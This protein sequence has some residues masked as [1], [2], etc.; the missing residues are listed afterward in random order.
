MGGYGCQ[1]WQKRAAMHQPAPGSRLAPRRQWLVAVALAVALVGVTGRLAFW[2]IG[3]HTALAAIANAQHLHAL[4]LA[5]GRGTIRDRNGDILAVT[6]SGDAVVLD[7]Q[8]TRA[9]SGAEPDVIAALVAA[10]GV[11]R[12]TI[13]AQLSLPTAYHL[14]AD[15]S[16][17]VVHLDA[18]V[19]D[20][21]GAR[22]AAGD[23]PGVALAPQ[24]WRVAPDGALASQVLGFVQMDSGAGQYGI[25]QD[26]NGVLAGTP[27]MLYTAVDAFGN[28]IASAPQRE[29]PAIPGGDV[30]LTL[31]A[32]L[33]AIAEQGLAATVAQEHASGG[34][35][36]IEDPATGAILALANAPD[37]DPNHYAAAPLADF[38][39]PAIA[40]AYDPGSTMKAM[41]MAAGIDS[42]VITPDTTLV[43]G[44]SF[45]VGSQ[46]I[47]NWGHLAWGLETMTQV[48]Q[49]SANVGAAWVAVDELGK[50]RFDRYLS[51]FGFGAPA[52]IGLPGE[53]AGLLAPNEPNADLA[54][55][56]LA[57]NAVGESIGV[58]PLQM[59]MAYGALADGGLLMR[60]RIVQSVTRDGRTTTF[61][62]VTVRR[63]VSPAAA[64]TVTQ[65][66]VE[67][68][69]HS[70]AEMWRF[71]QCAVAAKTGTST[72]DP[73]NPSVTFASV[74]GYFP[75]QAPHYVVLVKIDHPQTTIFGGAAAGPLW[76]ALARQLVALDALAPQGGQ[77]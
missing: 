31:D 56:D 24:S 32:S 23:L 18:Q 61:A 15:A 60:P 49:H 68:S 51:A 44:G 35:V 64:A 54:T 53:S 10:T 7:P 55:L 34:T 2:Q 62:P 57:E 73:A 45:T 3:Q 12:A 20:A 39:N 14:L 75:A 63:V 70:D 66:L 9:D 69:Q 8:V 21:L 26:E 48:L 25:E 77:S 41:T 28:P 1:A 47:Y 76:R 5:S 33:Q 22:I 6:V 19:S 52:G 74:I 36:I 71:T 46:T 17:A 50:A 43:D 11:S 16:G 72:P 42:G 65:M 29:T 30:T 58:T 40:S 38:A 27:G 67:S 13:A 4:T 37:F 59:V